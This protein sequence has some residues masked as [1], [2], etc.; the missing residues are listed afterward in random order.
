MRGGKKNKQNKQTRDF[1]PTARQMSKNTVENV[2][3]FQFLG[4]D[5]TLCA[6]CVVEKVAL[7]VHVRQQFTQRPPL[8]HCLN[9]LLTAASDR[10]GFLD[11]FFLRVR[12]EMPSFLK[13]YYHCYY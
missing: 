12:E 9:S 1:Y 13:Y 2:Q 7:V 8:H 4:G 10:D 6:Q 11:Q 3:L 5:T